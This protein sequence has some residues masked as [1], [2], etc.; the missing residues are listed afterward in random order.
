MQDEGDQAARVALPAE[1]VYTRLY[2][3]HCVSDHQLDYAWGLVAEYMLAHAEDPI[4]ARFTYL[5]R[6]HVDPELRAAGM[7]VYVIDHLR[8]AFLHTVSRVVVPSLRAG[9]LRLDHA[10]EAHL[11]FL[12]LVRAWFPGY[13][14]YAGWCAHDPGWWEGMTM[15]S[16]TGMAC[17]TRAA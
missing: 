12:Q 16:R 4:D 2:V 1:V 11:S 10:N 7:P 14:H 15:A 6:A 8:Y 5:R 9:S 13:V 3:A 17:V